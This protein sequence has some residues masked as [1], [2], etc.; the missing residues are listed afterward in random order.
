MGATAG[1][2]ILD[3]SNTLNDSPQLWVVATLETNCKAT[4]RQEQITR[5]QPPSHPLSQPVGT[6]SALSRDAA[7]DVARPLAKLQRA[8]AVFLSTQKTRRQQIQGMSRELS[9]VEDKIALTQNKESRLE[10]LIEKAWCG[11]TPRGNA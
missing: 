4:R 6:R 3:M 7:A 1:R 11:W 8:Q 9:Q 5:L 10:S 2:F